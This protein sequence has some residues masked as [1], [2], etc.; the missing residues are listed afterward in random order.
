V[1]YLLDTHILLWSLFDPKKLPVTAAA[2]ITEGEFRKYISTVSIWE[3]SLKYAIG[4]LE[5]QDCTP[6]DILDECLRLGY[7]VLEQNLQD[8]S[9][10]YKLPKLS[11]HKDPFDRM[12]IWQAICHDLVLLSHDDKMPDYRAHGL[13]LV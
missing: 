10:F 5:L 7:R 8:F 9:S 11:N 1:S 13:K 3:I 12:L 6:E 2:A 4:K